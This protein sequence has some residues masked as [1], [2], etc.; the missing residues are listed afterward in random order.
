MASSIQ[1][2]ALP[3]Q[4][5]VIDSTGQFN[6]NQTLTYLTVLY[7]THQRVSGRTCRPWPLWRTAHARNAAPVCAA[8]AAQPTFVILGICFVFAAIALLMCPCFYCCRSCGAC[9]GKDPRPQGYSRGEK[10]AVM[11]V[12]VIGLLLIM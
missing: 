8:A 4:I 5:V 6:I 11:I 9:G 2:A 3:G 10:R 1:A 12:L 7:R